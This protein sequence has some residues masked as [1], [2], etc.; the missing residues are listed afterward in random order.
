ML[1]GVRDCL[2]NIDFSITLKIIIMKKLA[3][4]FI[5][6]LNV[7]A[8]V[9]AE[10][11]R[12]DSDELKT[13]VAVVESSNTGSNVDYADTTR[14]AKVRGV[15]DNSINTFGEMKADL[16]K[17]NTLENEKLII[18]RF[19]SVSN[20]SYKLNMGMSDKS[21]L[22]LDAKLNKERLAKKSKI[23]RWKIIGFYS[24]AIILNGIGDGLNNT[25]QKTMGHIFN[26]A[27]I[28]MLLSTPFFV[29]YDKSK[30]YWYLL[31]YASLRVSLFDMTY[32]VTTKQPID[33]IGS[34]AITDKI[35]K[36]FGTDVSK[37]GSDVSRSMG[38]V[39]GMT[40]PLRLL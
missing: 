36:I 29:N 19:D 33:F 28:G 31:T 32:N 18:P 35:Y 14:V 4:L 15:Y 9:L 11:T 26:A 12:E 3:L 2:G 38:I 6:F 24:A 39:V 27:S 22:D 5:A 8:I 21:T 37:I 7:N 23:D 40:I 34:T 10:T 30:W 17:M 20:L 25:H 13:E 1:Q 16:N